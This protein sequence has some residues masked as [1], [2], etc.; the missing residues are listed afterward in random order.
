MYY[1]TSL[2]S[3]K[4]KLDLHT[5]K[6][7]TDIKGG[8][9][10]LYG[11][12]ALI[13]ALF[14]ACCGLGGGVIVKPL[15]DAFTS[16]SASEISV[17]ST[18][19]VLTIALTSVIRYVMQRTKIDFK[20]SILLGIGSALGGILGTSLLNLALSRVSDNVTTLIQS[21]LLAFFLSLGVL[22]ITFFKK[23]LSFNITNPLVIPLAGLLLGALASF[24]GVGGGPIN[25]ALTVLLFSLSIK[26]AAVSSLVIILISQL[27]KIG[28]LA[29]TGGL[30]GDLSPLIIML[31][32]AF[33]GALIGAYLNKRLP[34]K[35][36]LMLYN[37]AVCTVVAVTVINII[38]AI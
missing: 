22:Y 11:I 25:V 19:C 7:Y 26:E 10:M 33:V 20:R 6:R 27:T 23:K 16:L 12:I 15:L 24:A 3:R 18:F 14:G 32:I 29:F 37:T 9:F 34:E 4:T 13:A 30:S 8:E 36:V 17:I 31:P 2:K 35:T 28:T 1:I 38:R 21:V 5:K